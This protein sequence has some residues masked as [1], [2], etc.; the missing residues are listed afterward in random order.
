MQAVIEVPVLDAGW[1][2]PWPVASIA[3]GSWLRLDAGCADEEVG[4]FVAALAQH[5]DVDA[6]AG[7]DQVVTALLSEELLILAGGLQVIDTVT[8]MTVVPGCCAGLEDW[9]DW[10]QVLHGDSPWLGHDPGPE[11][12]I[13]GDDLR[14]WQDGG[15]NRRHGRLA[16]INVA[17]HRH[18]LPELLTTVQQDLVGFLAALDAWTRRIGIGESGSALVEAVNRNFTI[19][20]PLDLATV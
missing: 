20:A 7:R 10:A 16:R 9:R 17:M 15:P 1:P 18:L 13:A 19:T 4:L 2:R 6:P 11:V 8:G 12:E 14:V 5:L 3:P